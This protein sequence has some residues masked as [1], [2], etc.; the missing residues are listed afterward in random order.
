MSTL[1]VI[2]IGQAPRRDM[3]PEMRTWLPVDR[4]VERGAL[5]GLDREAIAL[6]APTD[7][8]E[9]LT[10]LL[11]DGS[12][13]VVGRAGLL[14]PIQAHIDDLE[15]LGVDVTLVVCTGEFPPFRHTKPLLM[16]ERLL[17]MGVAAVVSDVSVGIICPLPEQEEDS[18][19]KFADHL[20]GVG[21]AVASATPY[22]DGTGGIED[23][24]RRLA[25]GGAHVL[26]LDCM[27]YSQQHRKAA[28]KASGLPVI[29]A[30]SVVARLAA[31]LTEGG[32]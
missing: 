32:Q 31:E 13:V 12:W 1:G 19:T 4:L 14:D 16:A 7:G 22:A 28:S 8:D 11:V 25:E 18:R 27:G 29:L 5:D 26:V 2:T 10:T 15:R 3:V 9:S 30:R 21:V 6:L 23:A 17:A 24:A 20:P